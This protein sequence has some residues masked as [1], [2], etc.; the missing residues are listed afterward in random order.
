MKKNREPIREFV[1]L[2]FAGVTPFH[3]KIEKKYEKKDKGIPE[4]PFMGGFRFY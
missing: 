2:P 4:Y 3:K 1:C